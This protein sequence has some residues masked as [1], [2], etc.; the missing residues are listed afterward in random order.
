[1][2]TA[3]DVLTNEPELGDD[4]DE[5]L[6]DPTDSEFDGVVEVSSP[7]LY[8]YII[9]IALFAVAICVF[10]K[11]LSDRKSEVDEKSVQD[12]M[13]T[14][15]LLVKMQGVRYDGAAGQA[16]GIAE[17]QSSTTGRIESAVGGVLGSAG[18]RGDDVKVNTID[19]TKNPAGE[20]EVT[21]SY[22]R[23]GM[24]SKF[25][26]NLEQLISLGTPLRETLKRHNLL[27]ESVPEQFFFFV[28]LLKKSNHYVAH[29]FRT[30]TA[31]TQFY[32][33]AVLHDKKFRS[34]AVVYRQGNNMQILDTPSGPKS[35]GLSDVLR[36]PDETLA[37][38]IRDSTRREFR[39]DWVDPDLDPEKRPNDKPEAGDEK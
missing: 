6:I 15:Y 13:R 7:R 35:T 1:M 3:E 20:I 19:T 23:D 34:A 14:H 11:F 27:W 16:G 2:A 29:E 24:T 38:F 37:R 8:C 26:K 4:P 31:A 25:P 22:D 32:D 5:C 28:G 39:V 18:L 9:Q 12:A 36:F 10:S 21:V 30:K 33:S 17:G